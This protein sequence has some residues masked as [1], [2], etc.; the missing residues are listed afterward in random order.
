MKS[1][2]D[3]ARQFCHLCK[4]GPL[5]S[6]QISR[7]WMKEPGRVNRYVLPEVTLCPECRKKHQGQWK[8][9]TP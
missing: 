7:V 6:W 5:F 3:P 9:A 4:G 2:S 8:Y 1:T